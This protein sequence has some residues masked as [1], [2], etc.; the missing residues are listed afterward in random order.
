VNTVLLYLSVTS[1]LYY[2]GARALITRW[3]WSKYPSWLDSYMFCAACSGFA[4][5]VGVSFA[6]GWTQNLEFFGLPGR[7]WLTP[8]V[9]GLASMV[10]TPILANVQINALYQLGIADPRAQDQTPTSETGSPH[11]EA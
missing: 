7:F 8:V 2:L 3:I 1:A 6:I 9:S 10:W 11:A 4:Y 5:G